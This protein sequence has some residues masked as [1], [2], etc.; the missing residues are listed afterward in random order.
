MSATEYKQ[1]DEVLSAWLNARFR[2]VFPE[3]VDCCPSA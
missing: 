1:I 2:E 3:A